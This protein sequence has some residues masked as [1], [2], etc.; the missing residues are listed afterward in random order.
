M[1]KK[2]VKPKRPSK[3]YS[4]YEKSGEKKNRFC[5]KCGPGIFMAKHNDRIVCGTCHY[6]EFIKS[7][8]PADKKADKPAEKK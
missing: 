8:T 3:R 4:L 5:P 6:T 7:E 2:K 1:A